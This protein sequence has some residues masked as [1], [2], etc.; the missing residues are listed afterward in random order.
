M[1]FS[2]SDMSNSLQPHGW[3]HARLPSPS[4]YPG[5]CSNSCPT[6]AIQPSH[7]LSSPSPPAFVFPSIRVFSS[8]FALG[9]RWPKTGASALASVLPVNIQDWLPLGLTSL[10]SLLSK[11]LSRI[12][13]ST[14]VWRHQFFG[15]QPVL[16]SSSHI[17]TWLLEKPQLWLYGSL[18]A[19]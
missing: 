12:F 7:P 11:W 15:S 6:A 19:K 17:C 1:L 8:E 9:I 18:L 2:H 10:I 14:T 13:S 5:V 3:Q 4:Q 16:L